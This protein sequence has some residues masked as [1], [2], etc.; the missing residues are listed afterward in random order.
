MEAKKERPGARIKPDMVS[1]VLTFRVP[2]DEI[3]SIKAAAAADGMTTSAWLR[4]L[5]IGT[6]A[7]PPRERQQQLAT[8][9]GA[10]T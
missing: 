1:D 3:E 6:A 9:G 5:A 7:L 8:A 2:L 4:H 10:I